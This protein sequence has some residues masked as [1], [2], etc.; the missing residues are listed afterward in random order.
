ML[1]IDRTLFLENQLNLYLI[2]NWSTLTLYWFFPHFLNY[3]YKCCSMFL[4]S[5]ILNYYSHYVK[6][7]WQGMCTFGWC[8]FLFALRTLKCWMILL[9]IT[10]FVRLYGVPKNPKIY[11]VNFTGTTQRCIEIFYWVVIVVIFTIF[12]WKFFKTSITQKDQTQLRIIEVGFLY[13]YY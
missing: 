1:Q 13:F 9:A 7:W 3:V 12:C 8:P 11:W 2:L 5:G 6:L 4:T 10:L